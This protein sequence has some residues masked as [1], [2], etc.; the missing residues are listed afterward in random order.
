MVMN[1]DPDIVFLNE[2]LQLVE[3]REVTW[4]NDDDLDPHQFR[5]FKQFPVLLLIQRGS[6]N[7]EAVAGQSIFIENRPFL[8]RHFW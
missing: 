7:A 2:F 4:F 1:R 3:N 6:R 8:L 5:K